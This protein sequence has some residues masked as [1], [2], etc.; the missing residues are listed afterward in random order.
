VILLYELLKKDP[1][2]P[3]DAY[4]LINDGLQLAY[5]Q[6]GRKLHITAR[7]LLAAI[8]KIAFD[9]YGLLAKVVLQSWGISS[10]TDIGQMIA[11]LVNA[12]LLRAETIDPQEDFA[13]GFDL[14]PP[15]E[16]P[17]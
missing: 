15:A 5:E 1:R 12:G 10:G 13:A 11:N 3:V 6:T 16:L 9:R 8:R 7:E 2:Y 14:E 17:R 4:L